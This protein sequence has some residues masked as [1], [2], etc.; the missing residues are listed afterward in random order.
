MKE[1]YY[2]IDYEVFCK[3][4]DDPWQSNKKDIF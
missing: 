4:V 1:F 2:K 3:A